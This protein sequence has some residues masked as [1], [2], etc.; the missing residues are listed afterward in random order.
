[1]VGRWLA[2]TWLVST[3]S[4]RASSTAYVITRVPPCRSFKQPRDISLAVIPK[5]T[6]GNQTMAPTVMIRV[7][8]CFQLTNWLSIL[9]KRDTRKLFLVIQIMV[10]FLETEKVVITVILWYTIIQTKIQTAMWPLI[11]ITQSLKQQMESLF[12]PMGIKTLK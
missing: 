1:M 9:S 7:L 2:F 3:D 10:L 12:L 8:S 5:L 6:G 11:I 4:R